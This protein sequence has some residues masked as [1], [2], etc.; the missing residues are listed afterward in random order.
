MTRYMS[1]GRPTPRPTQRAV[2][3]DWATDPLPP[4][5]LLLPYGNGRSYGDQNLCSTGTLV[6]MRGLNRFVA[7][8]THKGRVTVESGVL[9]RDV[10]RV[11]APRGWILPAVPGTAMVTVGGAIAND[12][13]GKNHHAK[14]SF[15]HYVVEIILRRTDGTV[16]TLTPKDPLFAATVGGMGLTGFIVQATLALEPIAGNVLEQE[17][18]WFDDLEAFFA[19]SDSTTATEGEWPLCMGWLDTTAPLAKLGRGWFDRARWLPKGTDTTLPE[20]P[21]LPFVT[22]PFELP[23][24]PIN[25]LSVWAFNTLVGHLPRGGVR[26]VKWHGHYFLLDGVANT[27]LF[28]GPHGHYQFQFIV[29]RPEAERVILGVLKRVQAAGA[30]SFQNVIKL[31]G[32]QKSVGLMSF[33]RPGVNFAMDFLNRGAPTLRMLKDLEELI[34]GAGGALYPAKD[35]VMSPASFRAS[36]PQLKAFE[37]HVDP[38]ISSDLWA[39][40]HAAAPTKPQTKA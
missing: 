7:F 12:V 30:A 3:L 9:L 19:L 22:V 8:D 17:T 31:M 34:M 39:R 13:H 2:R 10:L 21:P 6:D 24:P 28:Y 1:W 16:H 40:V 32:P 29:P 5:G 35:A 27:N 36:Y 15:G 11:T 20:A 4:T 26:R 38:R 37:A 14:G 23:I 25:R 18:F 33:P